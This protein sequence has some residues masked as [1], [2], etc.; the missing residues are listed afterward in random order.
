MN[1]KSEL[2]GT[3]NRKKKQVMWKRFDK[4]IDN[5]DYGIVWQEIIVNIDLWSFV[6]YDARWTYFWLVKCV[7]VSKLPYWIK[8]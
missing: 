5:G 6:D 4:K 3:T 1:R 2:E 8:Q 7:L